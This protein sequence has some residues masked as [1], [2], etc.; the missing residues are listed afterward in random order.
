MEIYDVLQYIN[1][2]KRT[3]FVKVSFFHLISLY[4]AA[5]PRVYKALKD[6]EETQRNYLSNS[7]K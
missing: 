1:R 4:V 5:K 2:Y 6:N 7:L 3:D